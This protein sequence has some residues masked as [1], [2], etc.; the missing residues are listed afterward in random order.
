MNNLENILLNKLNDELI[1]NYA[2]FYLPNNL[3]EEKVYVELIILV[4]DEMETLDD[5]LVIDS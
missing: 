1:D 2:I 4:R 3:L 5:M